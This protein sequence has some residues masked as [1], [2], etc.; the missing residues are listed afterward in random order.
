MNP[1]LTA[2]DSPRGLDRLRPVIEFMERNADT[3]LTPH[4]LARVGSMSLRTLHATFHHELGMSAMVYLRSIRLDKVR[5]EL[6]RDGGT[7]RRVT[8]IAMRWGFSHPSRFAQQYR[9][10]FGELPSMTLRRASAAGQ[11]AHWANS[12]AP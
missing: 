5:S 1:P 12:S 2:A 11:P 3:R 9:D 6:L 10:R 8:D 7:G 4:L